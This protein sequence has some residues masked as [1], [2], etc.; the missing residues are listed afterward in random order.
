MANRSHMFHQKAP[1]PGFASFPKRSDGCTAFLARP[2]GKDTVYGDL[3]RSESIG[4]PLGSEEWLRRL[5]YEHA[6]SLTPRKCG[7]KARDDANSMD[8]GSFD[9]L[10]P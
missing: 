4:R 5:E 7:R 10:S 2:F 6:R 9:K 3:R 1:L 8:G